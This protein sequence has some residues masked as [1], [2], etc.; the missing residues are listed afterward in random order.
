[1]ERI[2][3]KDGNDKHIIKQIKK[4]C[5]QFFVEMV[6]DLSFGGPTVPE[7]ELIKM[8]LGT[9]FVKKDESTQELTPYKDDKSATD[10]IPTIRSFLLQLLLEHRLLLAISLQLQSFAFF[11]FV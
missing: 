10:K 11:Q 3:R 4:S 6:S 8:L 5:R 7:P 9:I 2:L 1:M